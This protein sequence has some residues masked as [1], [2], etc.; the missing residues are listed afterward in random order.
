MK[1]L[2]PTQVRL[3]GYSGNVVPT[4]DTCRI[5]CKLREKPHTLE[6]F[7][8]ADTH[9]TP[10]L[11]FDSCRAMGL[12]NI[13]NRVLKMIHTEVAAV[14]TV[15][16]PP[17]IPKDIAEEYPELF[18]GLGQFP[19]VHTMQTRPDVQ[20]VVH[21][22]RRVPFSL[23]DRLKSEL[24]KEESL[25]VIVKVDEPTDWVNSITI[26]EK[27]NGSLRICVDPRDLNK[28]LK[29]EHYSCPT[30]DDIAAKLH[31]ARVFTVLDA[32][33]GY[34]QVKLDKKSS[35]L[36]TF[37]TPFG[38][39][40]F[41]RV[42][43]GVNSAQDVF[44]KE[45]DLTYEGLPGVAAIVDDILMYGRNQEYR[46]M[47]SPTSRKELDTV[48]G[49]ATYLGKYA[50]NLS[51]VTAPLRDLTKKENDFIWDAVSDKAYNSMKRL[52]C[53]EPGPVIAYFYPQKDVVLQC[54]ASQKGLGAALL[55]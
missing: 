3:T 29:R 47:P 25:G 30:V 1:Q 46:D 11:G 10:I 41:T 6:F 50:P 44:Q 28:A 9:A 40:Q 13:E 39:Y 33:R 17:T 16:L 8:I 54:D 15:D 22:P 51:D 14:K 43:F 2:K 31:G 38:R 35:L 23:R 26:V 19:R 48:L 5:E 4:T 24:D 45:F 27:K 7:F 18:Q 32:T 55:Q 20:P 34:W 12:V 53:K 42:P 52:L 36:T 37:N 49:M 21:A